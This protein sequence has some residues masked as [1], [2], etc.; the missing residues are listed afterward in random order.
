MGPLKIIIFLTRTQRKTLNYNLA[1]KILLSIN[2]KMHMLFT[3]HL[4]PILIQERENELTRS[5]IRKSL[6]WQIK[7]N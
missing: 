6:F 2:Q 5:R 4:P 3:R 7:T 1:L